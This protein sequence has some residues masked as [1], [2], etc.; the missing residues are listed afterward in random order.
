[1]RAGIRLIDVPGAALF[2]ELSDGDQVRV[3]GA[4]IWRNGTLLAEGTVLEADDLEQALVAQQS[5]V[6]HALEDD[7]EVMT[8]TRLEALLVDEPDDVQDEIIRINTDA[9]DRALQMAMIVPA[10]AC[11]LGFFSSFRMM[12]LPDHKPSAAIEGLLAG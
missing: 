6:A 12:R 2:E 3:E 10:L 9:G 11:L 7:A 4:A 8:N 5:R 1:M